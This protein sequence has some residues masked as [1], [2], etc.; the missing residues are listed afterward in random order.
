MGQTNW[1]PIQKWSF[2]IGS[3][4]S[5]IC[6]TLLILSFYK[7]KQ[8]RKPP[9]NLLILTILCEMFLFLEIFY[10]S[11]VYMVNGHLIVDEGCKVFGAF[12]VYFWHLSW[13]Y[14]TCLAF[15][16]MYRVLRPTDLGY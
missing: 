14:F 13:N 16:I 8:M 6:C 12:A 3:P 4:T 2:Y 10:V 9:G 1:D 5:L 11:V 15:E 7:F